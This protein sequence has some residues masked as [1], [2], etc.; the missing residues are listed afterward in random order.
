MAEREAEV[1]AERSIAFRIG[2]NL[3]DVVVEGGDISATAS[4]SRPAWRDSVEPGGVRVSGSRFDQLQGKIEC[5]IEYIGELQVEEHCSGCTGLPSTAW[6]P[7]PAR[8]V[9]ILALPDRP[10][11]AV[12]PFQNLSSDADQ[13]YFADGIVEESSQHSR[14]CDGCS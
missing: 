7:M 13:D 10:S 1:A 9:P 2:V 6:L 14:A 4:T 12:L 8:P 11:I 3:G 5:N